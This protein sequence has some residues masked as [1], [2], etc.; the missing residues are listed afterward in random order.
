MIRTVLIGLWRFAKKPDDRQVNYPLKKKIYTV[1]VLLL[2]ELTITFTVLVPVMTRIDEVIGLRTR[3][4]TYISLLQTILLMV[5]GVPFFEE[6]AFRY[7]L[8]YSGFRTKMVSEQKWKRLFP[9]LVYFSVICFGLVHVTNY[10]NNTALFFILAPVIV[11]S[12]LT[13]GLIITFLRVR[14]SFFWGFF[15]HCLWNFLVIVAIPLTEAQFVEPYTDTNADYSITIEEELFFKK[16]EQALKIDS[17]G[18]KIYKLDV[19]QFAMQHL[20]DTLYKKNDYI[21]DDF[22]IN[23]K[24]QSEKGVT[25]KEFLNILQQEY[26]IEK[27]VK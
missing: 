21:T 13:G 1:L 20:L 15:Y 10:Y 27:N 19:E 25:E 12:Q 22:L 18:G 4:F 3:E 11:L 14:F 8:R 9:F 26:T 16:E 2:L 6:I 23:V 24:F 17:S 7:F 5:I